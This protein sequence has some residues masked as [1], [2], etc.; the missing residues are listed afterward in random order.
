MVERAELPGMSL[1]E[2]LDELRKRIIR[3]FI[4]LVL[5][6]GVAGSRRGFDPGQIWRTLLPATHDPDPQPQEINQP[7]PLHGRESS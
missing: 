6:F 1:M 3:S 4:F 2:H 5:G 7:A